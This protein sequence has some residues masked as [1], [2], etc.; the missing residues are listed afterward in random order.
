MSAL[1]VDTEP[2]RA[3]FTPR[4]LAEYLSMSERTIREMLARGEIASYK[5]GEN[6]R[7]IDP[8]D[9]DSYLAKRRDGGQDE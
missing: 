6:A 7:R 4:T 1:E 8:K 9:V 5:V 3:F 2:R